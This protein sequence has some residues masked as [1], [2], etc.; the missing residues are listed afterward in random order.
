MGVFATAGALLYIGPGVVSPDQDIVL[1]DYSTLAYVVVNNT[2][3]LGSFGDTAQSVTSDEIGRGRTR[4]VKGTRN[5]G[6]MAVT[7]NNNATD[8]GQIAMHAAEATALDYA[9]KIVFPDQPP[10]GSNPQGSTRYFAA[11]VASDAENLAGANSFATVTFNLDIDSNI[12][13]VPAS[14]GS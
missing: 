7:C 13:K 14:S 8:P 3:N 5:A 12:I 9:F 6:T 1:A 11:K 10:S 4:K 2:T